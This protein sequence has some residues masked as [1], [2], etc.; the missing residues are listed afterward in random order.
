M[1]RRHVG[2][3]CELL[4]A[5]PISTAAGTVDAGVFPEDVAD[6]CR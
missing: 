2:L 5:G 3:G 6:F 1:R 4:P